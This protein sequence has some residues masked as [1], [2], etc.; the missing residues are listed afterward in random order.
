MWYQNR[1]SSNIK[2]SILEAPVEIQAMIFHVLKL[3]KKLV[4]MPLVLR[5]PHI[6]M[7]DIINNFDYVKLIPNYVAEVNLFD[8]LIEY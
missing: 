4:L 3:N 7:S 6:D 8:G 5:E 2:S 1:L